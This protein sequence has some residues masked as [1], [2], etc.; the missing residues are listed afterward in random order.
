[1]SAPEKRPW[2]VP[3]LGVGSIGLGGFQCLGALGMAFMAAEM[4]GPPGT[5]FAGLASAW[6]LPGFLLGAGGVGVVAGTRWGRPLSLA[7]V[8]A[9]GLSLALVAANR[10][11]IPGA[12]ADLVEYGERQGGA[13][14]VVRKFRASAGGDPVEALRDPPQAAVSAW[15]FTAEC[16]CGTPW[17]LLVLA[18]CALPAGR[19]IATPT[20]PGEARTPAP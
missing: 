17:Y 19:R 8:A 5:V 20:P 10:A 9:M 14:E 15:V 2:W 7:A 4:G 11:A 6:F 1:M 3:R 13:A 16:G 12:V 18:A